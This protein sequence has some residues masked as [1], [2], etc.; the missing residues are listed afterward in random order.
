MIGRAVI[1]KHSKAGY[2]DAVTT[3]SW[4][5]QH[6]LLHHVILVTYCKKKFTVNVIAVLC[7]TTIS[8][9]LQWECLWCRFKSS[10]LLLCDVRES[11]LYYPF[12]YPA[13]I[14]DVTADMSISQAVV[15][16][17]RFYDVRMAVSSWR[18]CVLSLQYVSSFNSHLTLRAPALSFP[19]NLHSGSTHPIKKHQ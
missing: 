4:S 12:C 5:S 13:T 9:L 1:G 3:P 7:W 15:T 16:L 8:C 11:D 10:H 17:V 18:A 2:C 6:V 14:Y 19:R